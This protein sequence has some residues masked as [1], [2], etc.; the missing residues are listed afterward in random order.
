MGFLLAQAQDDG[1]AVD[2]VID[3]D[4]QKAIDR[5]ADHLLCGLLEEAD[6]AHFA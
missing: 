3:F 6:H 4:R 5:A 2:D 1:G